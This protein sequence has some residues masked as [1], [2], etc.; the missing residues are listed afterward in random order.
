MEPS[1]QDP[2]QVPAEQAPVEPQTPVVASA[3]SGKKSKKPLIITLISLVLI[4][5]GSC[6]GWYWWS[7]QQP[8]DS[9]TSDTSAKTSQ[10]QKLPEPNT[11]A[12]SYGT[13]YETPRDLFW[14]PANGGEKQNTPSKA[15]IGSARTHGNQVLIETYYNE[16]TKTAASILYSKDGGKTYETILTVKAPATSTDMGDQITGMTFASDGKSVIVAVLPNSAKNIVKRIFFDKPNEAVDIM[17]SDARGVF[18]IAFNAKSQ[19]LVFSEGCYNCDGNGASTS[20]FAYDVTSKQRST[21]VDGANKHLGIISNQSATKLLITTPTVDT[22]KTTGGVDGGFW[23]YYVGAPYK[24]TIFDLATGKTQDPGTT[25]GTAD[26]NKYARGGFMAN[27]VTPYYYSDN[28]LFM[29][30]KAT[31]TLLYES[32][33]PIHQVYYASPTIVFASTGDYQNFTLNR[34]DIK[35]QETK[36]LL[37]G[38]DTTTRIFG[39]TEN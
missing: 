31:P 6:A 30:D 19:K 13:S 24:F 34:F 11:I 27:G 5:V 7:L 8:V 2:K 36:Q 18:P 9:T 39:V 32:G 28:Q 10:Q 12:Y 25:V 33:Q 38:D 1:S 4:V 20:A 37:T 3:V 29:L 15:F 14:R 16:A 22:T 26:D 21:L 17:T 23:G 35:T